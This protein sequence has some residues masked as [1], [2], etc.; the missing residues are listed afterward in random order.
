MCSPGVGGCLSHEERIAALVWASA[1][2]PRNP[3]EEKA[4]VIAAFGTLCAKCFKRGAVEF[5]YTGTNQHYIR[6]RCKDKDCETL[7][8]SYRRDEDL[9]K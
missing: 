8:L 7:L 5:A 3:T 9:R 4:V 1:T 2:T 6:V